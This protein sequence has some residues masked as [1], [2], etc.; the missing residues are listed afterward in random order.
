ME[1]LTPQSRL[2]CG[3]ALPTWTNYL[4]NAAWKELKVINGKLD[5][6]LIESAA[7][8]QRFNDTERRLTR[9]EDKRH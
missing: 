6:L 5:T 9:L 4:S 1:S 3:R 8:G 7:N 2:R